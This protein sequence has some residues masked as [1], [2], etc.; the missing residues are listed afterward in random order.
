VHRHDRIEYGFFG[1]FN[2][3][4]V[5]IVHRGVCERRFEREVFAAMSQSA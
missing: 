3:D 1:Q 5:V 2:D 4:Q